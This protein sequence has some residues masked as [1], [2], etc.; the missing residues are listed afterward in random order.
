MEER[1]EEGLLG[2]RGQSYE[3]AAEETDLYTPD[4]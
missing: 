1:I 3:E 2:P 4:E